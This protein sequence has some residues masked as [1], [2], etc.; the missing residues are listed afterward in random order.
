MSVDLRTQHRRHGELYTRRTVLRTAL[1]LS[2]SA[3]GALLAACGGGGASAPTPTSGTS[4]ASRTTPSGGTTGASTTPSATSVASAP[5]PTSVAIPTAIPNAAGRIP[6]PGGDVPDAYPKFP[7]QLFKSVKEVPGKGGKVGKFAIS[8]APPTPPRNENRYWQELEKRLGVTFDAIQVPATSYEEKLAALTAGGDLPDLVWLSP[9]PD[10]LKIIGQGAY[11]DLTP[12]LGNDAINEWPNLA[13]YPKR[14]WDVVAFN[15]KIYGAPFLLMRGNNSFYFRQDWAEKVGMPQPKNA[16][17]FFNQMV[18]FT[19][20]DPDGNGKADTYALSASSPRPD[21]AVT[22]LSQMFRGPNNWRL[23]QDGTLTK[24][25]E[26]EEFKQALE[27]ARKLYTAGVYHPDAANLATTQNKDLFFGSKIGAYSDGL[28]GLLGSG[29]ARGKTRALTPTAN[30][31]GWVP[32]GHDG[33][34]AHFFTHMGYFG[35]TAIPVSKGKDKERV[36]ELLR[37]MDWFAAPFGSEENL[38]K[39][40]GIE[41]VHFTRDAEGRPQRTDL[42]QTEIG[43]LTWLTNAIPVCY[44]D[45]P[46]DAEYMQKLQQ[47]LLAIGVDDPTWGRYAPTNSSRAGELA[48]L[49]SDRIVAIVS[50]R[51]PM[52]AWD[53]FIKDWKGRGGDQIRKEYQDALQQKGG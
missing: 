23:N 9:P 52:T 20:N 53:Q 51:E 47:D 7:A 11:T 48:Q 32:V 28:G 49:Q 18:A 21:Y 35:Y 27:L 25:I 8:Y 43:G 6:S 12:Y 40:N 38:F 44:Y 31:T 50:G 2:V 4:G 45:V 37:I 46:G 16:D 41:G 34:R 33:G 30:V 22:T 19:K 42:G 14:I 17:E 15:G 36:K 29:G 10:H 13:G 39:I 24:N 26:T 3:S 5:T 1:A